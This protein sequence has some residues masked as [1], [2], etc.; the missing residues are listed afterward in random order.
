M[1]VKLNVIV[2]IIIIQVHAIQSMNYMKEISPRTCDKIFSPRI[3]Y[4][5][6]V[7][8]ASHHSHVNCSVRDPND[9][10]QNSNDWPMYI[11]HI[12]DTVDS[13]LSEDDCCLVS[14]RRSV[15]WFLGSLMSAVV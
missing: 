12:R 6:S 14:W 4:A 5:I 8:I 11:Y 2:M 13:C 7:M 15:A 9:W 3:R 1:A 10:F